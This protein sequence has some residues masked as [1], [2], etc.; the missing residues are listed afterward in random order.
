[1]RGA[2]PALAQ[3]AESADDDAQRLL[4]IIEAQERRLHVRLL[5]HL[6]FAA[7]IALRT[8]CMP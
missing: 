3:P 4:A 5:H 2:R 6:L 8:R 1:M 7:R